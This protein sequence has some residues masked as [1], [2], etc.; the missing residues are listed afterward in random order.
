MAKFKQVK[1][2]KHPNKKVTDCENYDGE[3][4]YECPDC[5][6]GWRQLPETDADREASEKI[7]EL[8]AKALGVNIKDYE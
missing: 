1:N 8:D 6:A 5:G 3:V 2:C 4:Y 7:L